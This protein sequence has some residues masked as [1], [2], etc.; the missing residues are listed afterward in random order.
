MP[1]IAVLA[2]GLATRLRPITEKIPKAMVEVAG[3]PFIAH[4]LRLLRRE[5]INRVVLCVGYLWEQI[6]E[7]AGDGSR[8][9]LSITYSVDGPR[10]LGTGGAVRTALDQLGP[11]FLVTY[12]DAWLDIPYGPVVAAFRQSG[13][14][15]LMTIFRNVGQWDAS[16]VWFE[17]GRIRLYDKRQRLPQMQ[18]IDWGLGMV[19]AH[20]VAARPAG[21]PF[22]LAEIYS[23]LSRSGELAG[24][25]VDTRFYEIGSSEGLL[26]TDLLLR[27]RR[28]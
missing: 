28:G 15:A 7:F 8:F 27:R 9:G 5:G 2:G 6:S 17:S 4:Q 19:K 3:E 23:E 13:K 12:G 26:E 11:E 14:P 10:L 1:P 21:V 22:D 25:E 20:L 16:N 18:H 24:Y